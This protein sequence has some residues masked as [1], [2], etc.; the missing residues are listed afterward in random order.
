[1]NFCFQIILRMERGC[2]NACKLVASSELVVERFHMKAPIWRLKRARVGP[3]AESD[4][5]GIYPEFRE[6]LGGGFGEGFPNSGKE[7]DRRSKEAGRSG[8]PDPPAVQR[9]T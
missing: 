9:L 3:K 5:N 1:M 2:R 6:G 4:G 7:F 8:F